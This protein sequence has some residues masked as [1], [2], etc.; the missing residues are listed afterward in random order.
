MKI[1]ASIILVFLLFSCNKDDKISTGIEIT[2]ESGNVY[3]ETLNITGEVI[4]YGFEDFV[5]FGVCWSL[6]TLPTV[7]DNIKEIPLAESKYVSEVV[8]LK[9][10]TK[11]H[12]RPFLL[13][14]D[15]VLYGEPISIKTLGSFSEALQG[16]YSIDE[17]L[18]KGY[19]FLDLLN[20]GVEVSTFIQN[21]YTLTDFNENGITVEILIE[22]ASIDELFTLNVDPYILLSLDFKLID[23]TG[24]G[25]VFDLNTLL[26]QGFGVGFLLKNGYSE[27][28]LSEAGLMGSLSD[29]DGNTY[30]WVK[31]GDQIWMAEDLQ[32]K[33]YN[34]GILINQADDQ[35]YGETSAFTEEPSFVYWRNNRNKPVIYN[36][37]A[38]QQPNICPVGWHVPLLEEMLELV[39][40]VNFKSGSLK[41][42][43]SIWVTSG[44]NFSGFNLTPTMLWG[45]GWW[46]NEFL[47][48]WLDLEKT[49]I[50]NLYSDQAIPVL[51]IKNDDDSESEVASVT[52]VIGFSYP[53][54]TFSCIRCIKD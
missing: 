29:I 17:L 4:N 54:Y 47:Y 16:E 35:V 1:L 40:N 31:I 30:R 52:E 53:I 18:L 34:N 36:G 39:D 9:P 23:L 33:H 7:L 11:Y 46:I 2:L 37:F 44:N 41:A 19:A 28:E 10:G 22:Y 6:D 12:F 48:L 24:A 25:Y 27:Q 51:Y 42:D 13:T 26:G 43:S 14:K 45:E 21:E 15:D 38:A 3:L 20:G 5:G 49:N 8:D 32:T 50:E